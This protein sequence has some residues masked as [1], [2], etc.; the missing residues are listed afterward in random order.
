MREYSLI[1]E[2][3]YKKQKEPESK[4]LKKQHIEPESKPLKKQHIQAKIL[5]KKPTN[6]EHL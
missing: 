1:V 4:P 3:P 5:S 6:L 2:K